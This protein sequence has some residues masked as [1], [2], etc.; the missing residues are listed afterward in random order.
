M[1]YT[2]HQ[3]KIFLKI[4]ECRSITKAA[5]ELHLTQPA[6][7]IQ[8]KRLQDQ[9]EIPLT[10]VIG[11]Q[12]YITDFGQKIVEVSQK[13]I[14]EA[15]AIKTTIDRYKGYLTGRI[16]ISVVSTGKYV[17]PYFLQAFMEKYPGVEM[18]I[19][20][21]NKNKVIQSVEQNETDF[22]L[23]SVLPK[24]PVKSIE[25]M[26]NRL[27]LVGSKRFSDRINTIEDLKGVTLIF[28]E[29]GSATRKAME[30]YLKK[31]GLTSFKSMELVSNE[32]VKQAVNAGIG[33]SIMP[34]IGLR[35]ELT[36]GS[37]QI[38]PLEGLPIITTWN[39][40]YNQGK[41]MTPAQQ[42]LI[43]YIHRQ[44]EEIVARFFNWN[45]L[46]IP[47]GLPMT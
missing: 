29:N 13:V 9:F 47:S 5:E 34:L 12:L 41:Q 24:I 36:V 21:S 3:L 39:L 43:H 14:T 11:R 23:V 6:V 8:L 22:S 27:F 31:K 32:A 1:N 18:I 30:D 2:L 42:E 38:F 15:E 16:K 20:V 10:E 4:A 26:E 46:N 7:S 33:F 45:E 35:N 25:L 19:D 17:I 44:K 40:I 37:M 28:R